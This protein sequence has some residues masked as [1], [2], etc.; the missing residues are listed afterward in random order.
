MRSFFPRNTLFTIM[1]LGLLS[2]SI[3]TQSVSK[4]PNPFTNVT[5]TSAITKLYPLVLKIQN[6]GLSL[7]KALINQVTA[8]VTTGFTAPT[9]VASDAIA[10][11]VNVFNYILNTTESNFYNLTYLTGKVNPYQLDSW[12][13]Y[14]QNF[15][16]A[17]ASLTALNYTIAS[18]QGPTIASLNSLN[19]NLP[20]YLTNFNITVLAAAPIL[21]SLTNL[22]N[23]YGGMANSFL[24]IQNVTIGKFQQNFNA[25]KVY[26]NTTYNQI[27]GNMS[28]T[29]NATLLSINQT[30]SLYQSFLKNYTTHGSATIN[31][32]Y[33][34]YNLTC[35][36]IEMILNQTLAAATNFTAYTQILQ[37]GIYNM[38]VT[39]VN[40]QI[41]NFT[42]F[43]ANSLSKYS[44]ASA[45]ASMLLGAN[46]AGINGLWSTF[47]TTN[48][49]L[50]S[51]LQNIGNFIMQENSY[52]NTK[53]STYWNIPSLNLPDQFVAQAANLLSNLAAV[54]DGPNNSA[55]M[56]IPFSL[57]TFSVISSSTAT[58]YNLQNFDSAGTPPPIPMPSGVPGQFLPTIPYAPAMSYSNIGANMWAST[59][60]STMSPYAAMPSTP[61]MSVYPNLFT[62]IGCYDIVQSA[63]NL[64][65]AS[66]PVNANWVEYGISLSN[67][68]FLSSPSTL[69]SVLAM[70][71][72]GTPN[73][74]SVSLTS[75]SSIPNP[76][77][78]TTAPQPSAGTGST[79][80]GNGPAPQPVTNG[81]NNFVM[82][83]RVIPSA[84][85]IRVQLLV[86]DLNLAAQAGVTATVSFISA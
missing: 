28:A 34:N 14:T 30:V 84:G 57:N 81:W 78:V 38:I 17:V 40:N 49:A 76:N 82:A 58:P 67:Y 36:P 48:A 11:V 18:D 43:S 63:A 79:G 55:T 42:T 20:S 2:H 71:M 13:I 54:F 86:T 8:S 59:S 35:L 80:T 46:Y 65:P 23:T 45:T 29:V 61:A 85:F 6:N 22:T 3:F 66:F 62:P 24:N 56:T 50:N 83:W 33:A 70:N 41:V 44:N 27:L 21:V 74:L 5:V 19:N 15:N 9:N 10:Q 51:L 4:I 26:S 60:Y 31:S 25:S 72:P 1:L 39:T 32:F 68:N 47:Q 16:A 69:I 52:V 75:A 77:G 73:L 64:F 37:S 53:S 7:N 12:S